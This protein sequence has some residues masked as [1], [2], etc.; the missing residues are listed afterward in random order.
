MVQGS[1]DVAWDDS[2]RSQ[3]LMWFCPIRNNSETG[4]PAEYLSPQRDVISSNT[5]VGGDLP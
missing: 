2:L 4:L 5:E 3:N 1:G